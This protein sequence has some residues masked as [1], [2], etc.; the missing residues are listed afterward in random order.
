MIILPDH[1]ITVRLSL[2]AIQVPSGLFSSSGNSPNT[3]IT[4]TE[5]LIEEIIQ[6]MHRLSP[7][8]MVRY[9]TDLLE[10]LADV[11]DSG[12]SSSSSDSI[13]SSDESNRMK[14]RCVNKFKR[15]MTE[16]LL[17]VEEVME[18]LRNNGIDTSI[19]FLKLKGAYS[20]SSVATEM[21]PQKSNVES[22][23]VK[24]SDVSLSSS[25]DKKLEESSVVLSYIDFYEYFLQ[26]FATFLRDLN[27]SYRSI[28]RHEHASLIF[29]D[30]DS[31]LN[32]R[33][34]MDGNIQAR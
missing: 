16:V 21:H 5:D 24:V 4:I 26:D 8:L 14:I 19:G 17:G 22:L 20:S 34:V 13:R 32:A 31:A 33:N 1:I 12:S 15:E 18:N 25:P 27:R 3:T 29:L 30:N 9:W 6:Q 2:P 11:P 28:Q 23:L 10:V 7:S